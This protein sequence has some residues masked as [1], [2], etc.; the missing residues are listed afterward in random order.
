MAVFSD[1]N[2]LTHKIEEP[3]FAAFCETGRQ[4]SYLLVIFHTKI[5]FSYDG[6]DYF[7]APKNSIILYTPYRMQ[8]YRSDDETFVNSFMGFSVEQEYFKRFDFPF[9]TLF[10]VS[11]H[12]VD[13]IVKLLDSMSFIVNTRYEPFNVKNIPEMI[14]TLFATLNKAYLDSVL[15]PADVSSKLALFS[16][17]RNRMINDPIPNTVKS[18]TAQSGYSATYF[19]ICYKKFFGINPVRD[20]QFHIVQIIKDYLKTSNLS[21][22]KIAELCS[23]ESVPYMI[24]VFKKYEKKTPHQYRIEFQRNSG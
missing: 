22:E 9:D 21:L 8:A 13:V 7:N 12:D 19:S 20:R 14:D 6:K 11:R 3:D 4:D 15:S 17:I 10:T 24:S 18:M 16:E 1:I 23:F 5:L 2:V